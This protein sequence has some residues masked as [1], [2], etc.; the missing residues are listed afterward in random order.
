MSELEANRRTLAT[1]RDI[2]TSCGT[3]ACPVQVVAEVA[4][5]V[6]SVLVTLTLAL[7]LGRGRLRSSLPRVAV[8][9][10]LLA[11]SVLGLAALLGRPG[12]VGSQVHGGIGYYPSGHTATALVCSA[13]V[14]ALIA[15]PSLWGRLAATSASWTVLVGV[16][17]VF[18][19]LHWL[20]DVVGAALLGGVIVLVVPLRA[21][22][23]RDER[24]GQ[25]AGGRYRVGQLSMTY[26][27]VNV[28][29]LPDDRGG[30][31]GQA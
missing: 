19:G 21:G 24:R 17:M 16:S 28:N 31:F 22:R 4:T 9:L 1:E 13:T 5:S 18:H 12:P 14:G 25:L 6:V 11:V 2:A 23:G 7:W 20:S 30:G 29:V 27:Q 8:R 26:L 15:E 10:C 3:G